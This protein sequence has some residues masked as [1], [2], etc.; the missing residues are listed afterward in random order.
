MIAS[1]VALVA[2]A[3]VW[4]LV[5]PSDRDRPADHP[6][7]TRRSDTVRESA[8][9]AVDSPAAA[10]AVA[11]RA[12][13]GQVQGARPVPV[14]YLL[15]HTCLDVTSAP[16]VDTDCDTPIPANLRRD[17]TAALASFSRLEFVDAAAA[18]T[19]PELE[20]AN[21]GVLTMLGRVRLSARSGEVPLAVRKGG[22]NGRGMTYRLSYEDGR[23]QITGS[24]GSAWIS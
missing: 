16:P 1:V 9:P 11:I 14:I 22:L 3:T 15:D 7:G 24:T 2:A 20:I 17:L 10:Y 6:S 5:R 18:V 4:W 19:G 13:A 23:W 12:L 8:G 21:D